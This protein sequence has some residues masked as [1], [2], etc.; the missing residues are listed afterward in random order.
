M[1][2][3]EPDSEAAADL[4]EVAAA[5]AAVEDSAEADAL[6]EGVVLAAADA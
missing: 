1:D 6:V 3:A 5:F 4:A 2:S